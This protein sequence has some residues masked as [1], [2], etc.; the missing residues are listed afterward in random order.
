[1]AMARKFQAAKGKQPSV[2]LDDRDT[3]TPGWNQRMGNERHL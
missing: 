3:Y 1:M 2:E